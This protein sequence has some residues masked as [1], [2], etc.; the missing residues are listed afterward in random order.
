[1]H[2]ERIKGRIVDAKEHDDPGV[3]LQFEDADWLV[4]AATSAW[5]LM[6]TA[7]QD[8][9]ELVLAFWSLPHLPCAPY[10]QYRICSW[11]ALEDGGWLE[12]ETLDFVENVPTHW[13]ALEAP[14]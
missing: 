8:G 9:R 13:L 14:E 12:S 4:G 11:D 7:P 3:S 10:R 1:M 6:D 2:L 5:Q